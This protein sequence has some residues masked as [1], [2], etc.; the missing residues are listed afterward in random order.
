M[1]KIIYIPRAC[2]ALY[3]QRQ[4]LGNAGVCLI[5]VGGSRGGRKTSALIIRFAMRDEEPNCIL[6]EALYPP[7]VTAAFLRK[8]N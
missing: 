8:L 1:T 5:N 4:S 6:Y 3:L 2:Y 7:L